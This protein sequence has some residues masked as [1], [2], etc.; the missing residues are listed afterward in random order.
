MPF[1]RF[2]KACCFPKD[3][4][5]QEDGRA[6]SAAE[7]VRHFFIR[8]SILTGILIIG[9]LVDVLTTVCFSGLFVF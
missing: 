6:G 9:A 2:Q 4:S 7:N 8:F 3:T 5:W 1:N